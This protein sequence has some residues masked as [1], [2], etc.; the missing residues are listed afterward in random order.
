MFGTNLYGNLGIGDNKDY[1]HFEPQLVNYFNDKEI[2]IK[3]IC[4][5]ERNTIALSEDGD[6]YTW[7]YG[8]RKRKFF[9]IIKSNYIIN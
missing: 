3:K 6:V 1:S 9:P 2:K 8:G 7:G 5:S 4:C